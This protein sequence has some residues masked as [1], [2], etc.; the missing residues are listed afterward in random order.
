MIEAA[1]RLKVF[2]FA[3][4]ERDIF[5][6]AVLVRTCSGTKNPMDL[7]KSTVFE[8]LGFISTLHCSLRVPISL[9]V[10][11]RGE[12]KFSTLDSPVCCTVAREVEPRE[13]HE[14]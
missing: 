13:W 8:M 3:H 14:R 12:T 5:W 4:E 11:F 6:E 9:L 10:F 1:Y 7:L 2:W